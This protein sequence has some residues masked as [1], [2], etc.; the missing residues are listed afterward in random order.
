LIGIETQ[1]VDQ[2]LFSVMNWRLPFELAL[3]LVYGVA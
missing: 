2:P 3:T 1:P